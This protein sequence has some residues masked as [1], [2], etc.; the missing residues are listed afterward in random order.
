MA[1]KPEQ[2]KKE[3]KTLT[4]EDIVAEAPV[5]RRSALGL[6]GGLAIGSTIA[7][8]LAHPGEAQAVCRRR[9]GR[10][11]SDSGPN[12][13]GA[14]CGHTGITDSDPSDGVGFGRGG[15]RT[16]RRRTGFTDRDS[17][18]GADG[19]GYGVCPSRGHTDSDGGPG[20]DGAGHGRG[21]C[22]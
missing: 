4:D 7:A 10:T 17:G 9:T 18:P 15:R 11:D 5:N 13:D 1:D 20:A 6:L 22:H 21:P 16:A 14:G 8:V 19:A 12:A 2:D 3:L